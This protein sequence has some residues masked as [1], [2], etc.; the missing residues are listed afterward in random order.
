MQGM[1]SLRQSL[2][3]AVYTIC[4]TLF[5]V[6]HPVLKTMNSF[7]QTLLNAIYV[8]RHRLP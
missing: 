2:L 4:E 8:A 7:L 3:E 5:E 1:D 6:M